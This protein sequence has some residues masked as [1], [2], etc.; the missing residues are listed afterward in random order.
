MTLY[1]TTNSPLG[2]LLLVG[3]EHPEGTALA[4]LSTP[5]QKGGA[6]VQDGWVRAPEAFTA[7]AAQLRA[8]FEGGLTRFDIPYVPSGSE[9]QRRVWGALEEIPYGTTRTYGDIA[10]AIGA[11]EARHAPWAPRSAPTPSWSSAPATASSAPAAASPATR[12][13]STA[14]ATS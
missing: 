1:T 4:S 13:A 14:S 10:G 9:F 5:G 6:V 7:I 11:P 8:Y 3:E 2:D 12:A